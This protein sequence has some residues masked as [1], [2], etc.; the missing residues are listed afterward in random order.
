LFG[1]LPDCAVD[2]LEHGAF[3]VAAPVGPGRVEQLDRVG[4]DLLRVA[5]VRPP[6]QV[7]ERATLVDRELGRLL[8]GLTILIRPCGEDTVNQLLFV[9]L[10]G[11]HATRF[12]LGDLLI[13]EVVPLGDD[14]PH[15][16]LNLLQV[17]RCEWPGQVEVVVETVLDG[18][19]DG[20]LTLGKLLQ[21][22]LG[23]HVRCRVAQA[24]HMILYVFV[25]R[26]FL[27]P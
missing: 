23:H 21:H 14:L 9:G 12:L 2:A 17:F 8:Q 13:L 22:S 15:A 25:F 24:M 19:A 4:V 27:P 18:R 10:I 7:Y 26:H 5:H 11:E 1:C 6:A 16:G 3:L 20:N